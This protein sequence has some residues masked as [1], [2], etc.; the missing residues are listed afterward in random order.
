MRCKELLPFIIAA[1]L[2]IAWLD[3]GCGPELSPWVG[4]LVPVALASRYCGFGTGAFYSTLAG[5]LIC[6]A[7]KYSGHP[8]SSEGYLLFVAASQVLALLVVAW[9][10]ARTSQLEQALR[11]L[12][13]M[14]K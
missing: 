4:Y 12:V 2:G 1:M 10:V 3:I 13:V 7:A 6:L 9:L 5:L 11:G 8:Y 14:R